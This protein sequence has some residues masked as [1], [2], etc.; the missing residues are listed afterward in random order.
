M[1]NLVYIQIHTGDI[2]YFSALSSGDILL[3]II[4]NL[5]LVEYG[6]CDVK[7]HTGDMLYLSALPKSLTIPIS[8]MKPK[9]PTLILNIKWTH[10]TWYH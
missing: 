6:G 8:E 1:V 2:L 10:F 3:G 9:K 4:R 7:I 5:N